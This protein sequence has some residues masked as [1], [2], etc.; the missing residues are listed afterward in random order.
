MTHSPAYDALDT[1]R[2]MLDEARRELASE[3]TAGPNGRPK[4][5][6]KAQ[7]HDDQVRFETLCAVI[8]NVTGRIEPLEAIAEQELLAAAG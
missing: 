5:K 1:V 7:R 8:W 2:W 4:K 3:T 6:S